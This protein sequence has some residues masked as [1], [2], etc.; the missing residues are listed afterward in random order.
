MWY[1][2]KGTLYTVFGLILPVGISDG[3]VNKKQEAKV[4]REDS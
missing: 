1:S 2:G 3:C 4:V